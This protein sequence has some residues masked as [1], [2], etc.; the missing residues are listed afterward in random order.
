MLGFTLCT[1]GV[2][3]EREAERSEE[4]DFLHLVFCHFLFLSPIAVLFSIL[5]VVSPLLCV[6]P[7]LT[8]LKGLLK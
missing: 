4:Q 7:I 8:T 3:V 6:S 2:W 5:G 1:K